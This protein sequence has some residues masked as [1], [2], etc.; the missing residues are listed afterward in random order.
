MVRKLEDKGQDT[1]K[2][3]IVDDE[4][5]MRQVLS[6]ILKREGFATVFATNG[7]EAFDAVFQESPHLIIM[8]DMM[9]GDPNGGEVCMM[10]KE[11]RNTRHIPVILHSAGTRVQ[12]ARFVHEIGADAALTKPCPPTRM[13]D[14]IYSLLDASV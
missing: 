8:D 13:L 3:L 1:L 11:N 9:P 7:K 6:I 2:V 12:S 5:G 10:L 14:T 4:P